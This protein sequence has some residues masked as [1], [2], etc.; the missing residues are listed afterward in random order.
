MNRRE[1]KKK[2]YVQ[3]FTSNVTFDMDVLTSAEEKE[4]VISQMNF[5]YPYMK[6]LPVVRLNQIKIR[7]PEELDEVA[8]CTSEKKI[9][10]ET[11]SFSSPNVKNHNDYVYSIPV[12]E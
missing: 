3:V 5:I 6:S 4:A 11:A 2:N 8:E 12:V 7:I 9:A 10:A 1:S